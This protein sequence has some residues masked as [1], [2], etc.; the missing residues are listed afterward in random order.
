MNECL[1]LGSGERSANVRV[2]VRA[3][4]PL[5]AALDQLKP[6]VT[7]IANGSFGRNPLFDEAKAIGGRLSLQPSVSG[8]PS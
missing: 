7:R 3:A 8:N 6:F 4:T 5:T 1:K 2:W